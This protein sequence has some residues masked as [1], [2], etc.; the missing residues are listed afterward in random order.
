MAARADDVDKYEEE[1]AAYDFMKRILVGAEYP[2]FTFDADVQALLCVLLR[3]EKEL[4]RLNFHPRLI[5]GCLKNFPDHLEY[6]L[7]FLKRTWHDPGAMGNFYST[8]K[9]NRTF[10]LYKQYGIAARNCLL[11]DMTPEQWDYLLEIKY[12]TPE[13]HAAGCA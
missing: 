5:V 12:I 2:P 9:S 3:N 1:I 11:K 6:Y 10:D 4:A 8:V 13:Q 7:S